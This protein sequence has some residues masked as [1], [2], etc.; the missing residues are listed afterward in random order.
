MASI[1]LTLLTMASTKPCLIELPRI[2]DPRG[3]LSFAQNSDQIPFEIKRVFWLY[4]VPGGALRGSHSH[5]EA[6]ELIVATGGSFDVSLH[7][8]HTS[9]TY[10]LNRPFIGLYVPPGYWR[11][12]ENFS[13]G[14]VCMV[15]DSILYDESDYIR[16]FNEFLLWVQNHRVNPDQH[17]N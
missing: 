8:G 14:S 4:D 12:L 17:H 6:H 15:L 10:T 3:S 11:T 1:S 13:S 9:T 2:Y 7:D 5:R 16:D